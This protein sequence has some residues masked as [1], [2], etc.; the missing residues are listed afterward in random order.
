MLEAAETGDAKL[1]T[2]WKREMSRKRKRADKAGAASELASVHAQLVA[3]LAADWWVSASRDVLDVS[4]AV[5]PLS[6]RVRKRNGPR[7]QWACTAWAKGPRDGLLVAEHKAARAVDA[8]AGVLDQ[9]AEL[10]QGLGEV[11]AAEGANGG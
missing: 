7:R 2:A 3:G 10:W 5:G 1:D 9:V 11:L 4:A 6:I 8:L